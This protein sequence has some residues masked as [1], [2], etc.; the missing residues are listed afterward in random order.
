MI[1]KSILVYHT[2]CSPSASVDLSEMPMERERE[3]EREREKER[4]RGRKRGR[5]NKKCYTYICICRHTGTLECTSICMWYTAWCYQILQLYSHSIIMA[6]SHVSHCLT[7][8]QLFQLFLD[9]RKWAWWRRFGTR[10]W[11]ICPAG[12]ARNVVS[13]LHWTMGKS[14][15]RSCQNLPNVP[16]KRAENSCPTCGNPRN[17]GTS[18]FAK[19][20]GG[21][22]WSHHPKGCWPNKLGNPVLT[23][24]ILV[25]YSDVR[26]SHLAHPRATTALVRNSQV[27][28]YK[29]A[30]K[31]MGFPFKKKKNENPSAK[32]LFS[33]VR[34]SDVRSSDH[35]WRAR[36][37]P[38]KPSD[39]TSVWTSSAELGW[40]L[41]IVQETRFMSPKGWEATGPG[42][43]PL[44]MIRFQKGSESSSR[45]R[46]K[47]LLFLRI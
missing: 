28:C 13:G 43:T 37:S 45:S 30:S 9:A 14:W 41:A 44:G 21:F 17:H 23:L 27:G 29:D 38:R 6:I 47:K 16:G 15:H 34:C 10:P 12:L 5:E 40:A 11:E 32:R 20:F 26:G 1:H 18:P 19:W 31:A 24:M 7:R 8:S 25:S 22:M 2:T 39:R 36:Q 4:K 46:T 33:H 42:R 3:R 35:L